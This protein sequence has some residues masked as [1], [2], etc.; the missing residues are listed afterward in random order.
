MRGLTTSDAAD[1]RWAL[2]ARGLGKKYGRRWALEDCSFRVP[3]GRIAALV[4]PNG[5]GKSTLLNLATRLAEPSA[6]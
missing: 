1:H 3:A 2:E 4:G 6:A 5:A